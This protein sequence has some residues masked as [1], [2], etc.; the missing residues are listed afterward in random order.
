MSQ[1]SSKPGHQM[2]KGTV[3]IFLAQSLILPT[4]FIT[5]VFLG[6][7]LGP[8]DYGIFALVSRM[9][10]W[11]EWSGTA[12]FSS[13]TI[14][15]IGDTSDWKPVAS[16][17]MKLHLLTGIFFFIL[18]WLLSSP[19]AYIFNEPGISIYLKI[20]AIDIP[21]F[22]LTSAHRNILIGRGRF[23]E[24]AYISAVRWIARLFL[25]I[26]FVEMGLTVKGAILGSIGASVV[27]LIMC[28]TYLRTPLFSRSSFPLRRFLEFGAPLFKAALSLRIFRMDLF[29][30]KILGGTA[31]QAGYYGAALN[32]SIP[33]AIYSTSLSPPLLS[34]LSRLLREGDKVKAKKIGLTAIRSIFWLLPLAAMT[35][36]SAMEIVLFVFGNKYIS[37]GPIL[38]FLIW[39][40]IGLV[41]INISNAILIALGK[42]NWAYILTGPMV[43][44]ALMGHAILIPSIGMT[45][46]AIVTASVACL[47]A[48]SSL[49]TVYRIWH[50][51]PPMLSIMKSLAVSALSYIIAIY[52]PASGILLVFKL[53]FIIL[54]TLLSFYL[55]REFT[56]HEVEFIR[57]LFHRDKI[58]KE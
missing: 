50:I 45:G 33:P 11:I 18:L 12:V 9:L 42:P 46:A 2:F 13:T 29:I 53:F 54:I 20:F 31:A 52:W 4:G 58:N 43:P 51:Y 48:V 19:L 27:E 15:F 8:I 44:V 3:L 56:T 21:V 38:A 10:V 22:S 6:R 39:A 47:G 36:G 25:I 24:R 34:T 57:S 5:A 28:R 23:K 14:K 49:I 26:L 55:L 37:A 32:L 7:K 1:E 16:T 17:V 30:L 40:A 35:T 41:A